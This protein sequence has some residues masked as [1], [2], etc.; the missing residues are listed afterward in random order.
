MRHLDVRGVSRSLLFSHVDAAIAI[1]GWLPAGGLHVPDN[2]TE[3]LLGV[4]FGP[5]LGGFGG[6]HEV[7][8]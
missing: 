5:I 6:W 2:R 8:P 4:V 7:G 3:L 1:P